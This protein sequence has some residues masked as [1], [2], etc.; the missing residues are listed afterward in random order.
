MVMEFR[1]LKKKLKAQKKTLQLY[2]SIIGDKIENGNR[3][4]DVVDKCRHLN[5]KVYDIIVRIDDLTDGIDKI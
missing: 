2:N 5:W 3:S 1:K 4:A